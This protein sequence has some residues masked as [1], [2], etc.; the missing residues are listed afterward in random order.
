[1]SGYAQAEIET[2]CY[3]EAISHGLS[4]SGISAT[5]ED[6][7]KEM[8]LSKKNILER[9]DSNELGQDES[10]SESKHFIT[11]VLSVPHFNAIPKQAVTP[12]TLLQEW[13]GYVISINDDEFTAS[14][15]DLTKGKNI[16]QEEADFSI[17]DLTQD[18]KKLL[19]PGAVFRWIIGYRS[20]GGTKERI[21]KIVF[22]R[23]PQWTAKDLQ[24]A[25]AK[26]KEISH[27]IVWE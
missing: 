21:S 13:E 12:F 7:L 4:T 10:Q 3:E 26:A 2:T 16:E 23:M 17:D 19:K 18:D 5:R 24:T 1:M 27:T 20:I 11:R 9:N 6:V 25:Q 15:L 22:R 8:Y 14:L